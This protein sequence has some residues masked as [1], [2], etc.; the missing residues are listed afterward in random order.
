[1]T[2]IY[3]N[4]KIMSKATP[5]PDKS[6]GE[7]KKIKGVVRKPRS[8]GETPKEIM[9]KHL[10]DKNHVISE[11]DFKNLDISIDISNDSSHEPLVIRDAEGRPKDEDKDAD[12]V[13]PWDVIK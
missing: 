8:K 11:E 1:V 10:K 5:T 2:S 6:K 9:D 7:S 3:I 12:I 13:T 4:K